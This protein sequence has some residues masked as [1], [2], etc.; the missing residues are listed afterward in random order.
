MS[1]RFLLSQSTRHMLMIEPAVFFAN[2]E[3]METNVYQVEEDGPGKEALFQAAL[4]EF[5][6][7]RDMLVENGVYVTTTCGYQECPDMVFPNWASTHRDENGEGTLVLYPMLNENRQAERAPGMIELCKRSYANVVDLT[8][9]EKEG[10]VLEAQG[11]LVLDRVNKI[12][13]AALSARTDKALVEKWGELMGYQ[14][15]IFNTKSHTGQPVYHTDLIIHIGTSYAGVCAPAIVEEDR[16][17]VV[18]SLRTTREVVEF[19]M[20]Q[21]QSFCGNALE[22]LGEGNA[23]MLVLSSAAY[24]AL[25][26]DQ[27]AMMEK[28]FTRLLHSPLPTLEKYGGGSA[29]CTLMEMF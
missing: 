18:D 14:T 2:P 26:G 15:V 23:P 25:S 13:Y 17:R 3:T 24:A 21:L 4:K 9:H 27:R 19:S 5:R 20:D 29:R 6:D 7:F 22:V 1:S 11:S 10:R 16:A 12:A 8:A 28:H